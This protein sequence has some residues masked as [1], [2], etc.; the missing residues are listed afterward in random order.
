M[1]PVLSAD[2]LQRY[3][4]HTMIQE[5]GEEG[6]RTLKAASVLVVGVG[7]LGSPIALYLAAAGVG[8]LGLIDGDNVDISNL[9][10]Q[11]LYSTNQIGQSK[12]WQARQRLNALNPHIQIDAYAETFN[13]Q[14]ALQLAEIGRASCRERV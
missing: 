9:Q 5:V 11:V 12:A 6:Q 2:E 13:P 1:L 8:R 14:N 3:K 4:R 7:G 10:R